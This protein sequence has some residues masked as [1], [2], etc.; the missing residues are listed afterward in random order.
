MITTTDYGINIA[1]FTSQ[2]SSGG[3]YRN[4]GGKV[5]LHEPEQCME[6]SKSFLSLYPIKNCGDHDGLDSL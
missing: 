3:G 4:V 1:E 2:E 5:L 6:C